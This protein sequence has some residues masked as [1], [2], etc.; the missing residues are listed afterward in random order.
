MNKQTLSIVRTDR[1]DLD[2]YNITDLKGIVGD[3]FVFIT[4]DG[5]MHGLKIAYIVEF[6]LS[7]FQGDTASDLYCQISPITH[8]V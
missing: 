5:V 4:D 7:P 2:I 3:L 6:E 1:V 8:G